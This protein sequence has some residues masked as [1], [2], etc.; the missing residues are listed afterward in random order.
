MTLSRAGE[1][2]THDRGIMRWQQTVG[3]VRWRRIGLW[4]FSW[5]FLNGNRAEVHVG[6]STYTYRLEA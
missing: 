2:R 1:D 3:M 4:D 6:G 5:D